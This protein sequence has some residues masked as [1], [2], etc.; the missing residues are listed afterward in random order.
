M[1]RHSE[2]DYSVL[3]HSTTWHSNSSAQVLGHS[4]L[5]D[6]V[7]QRLD[8][9]T[10]MLDTRSSLIR[11]SII[12]PL[13]THP[14]SSRPLVAEFDLIFK[15]DILRLSAKPLVSQIWFLFSNLD[16][17]SPAC[18]HKQ[19]IQHSIICLLISSDRQFQIINSKLVTNKLN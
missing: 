3:A 12:Q 17:S 11:H 2:F 19:I 18:R 13:S 5:N 8:A 14:L 16:E 15:I 4:T 9:Q 1:T 6:S 7:T 10:R